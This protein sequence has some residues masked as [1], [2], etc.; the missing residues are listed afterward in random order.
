MK[1]TLWTLRNFW[2][3]GHN[4]SFVDDML[5][6]MLS[7]TPFNEVEMSVFSKL[8]IVVA[9]DEADCKSLLLKLS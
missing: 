5:E 7:L 4:D 2:A 9:L 1:C 6:H 3:K 8:F